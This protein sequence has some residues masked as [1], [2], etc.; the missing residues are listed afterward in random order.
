MTELLVLPFSA[1]PK[2]YNQ[3]FPYGSNVNTSN[4]KFRKITSQEKINSFPTSLRR[5]ESQ[6]LLKNFA[7]GPFDVICSQGKTAKSH[8]GNIFFQSVI[9]KWAEEY[10]NTTEKRN[11]SKIVR[12]IIKT[13]QAKSPN[14][15]FIRKGESGGWRVVA[16]DQAR[17]KVSQSLRDTLAG[18]YRSSLTAKKR[19]RME[20]NLKRMI[21]FEE[22]IGANRFVSERISWLS[23]TI[24][25]N[26]DSSSKSTLDDSDILNLMNDTNHR[27]LRQLKEDQKVEQNVQ[28]GQP[29][30]NQVERNIAISPSCEGVDETLKKFHIDEG[31]MLLQEPL[32]KRCKK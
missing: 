11:K 5:C 19:S 32:S 13:I 16:L 31:F 28:S 23:E 24:K 25:N 14:G 3:N 29:Q 30:Q 12:N 1:L 15:G 2:G 26:N 22:V 4:L 21:D 20:S 8:P 27:I 18:H 9:R 10:A 6:E 7:P 17:E